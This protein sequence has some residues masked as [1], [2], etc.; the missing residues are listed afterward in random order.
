MFFLPGHPA[1]A[2]ADK[3]GS[4]LDQFEWPR[5][6]RGSGETERLA[7]STLIF[8]IAAILLSTFLTASAPEIPDYN[9]LLST[10]AE[11]V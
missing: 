8:T 3:S 1:G 4:L 7:P 6:A 11:L 5:S 9:P 2:P 10:K